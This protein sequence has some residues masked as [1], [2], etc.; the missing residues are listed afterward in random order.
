M[1]FTVSLIILGVFAL[2]NIVLVLKKKYKGVDIDVEL[3]AAAISDP[4]DAKAFFEKKLGKTLTSSSGEQLSTFEINWMHWR[5]IKG[6]P[7]C[8]DCENGVLKAGP[9]AGPCFVVA[10]AN[11]NCGSMFN[12]GL[13]SG[14]PPSYI[15]RITD[16]SPE[17]RIGASFGP[18]R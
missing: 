10:C 7:A 6:L 9:S 3:A 5:L 11:R 14:S 13:F 16:R 1:E 4:E 12:V 18:H 17:E 8:I 2:A 15:E